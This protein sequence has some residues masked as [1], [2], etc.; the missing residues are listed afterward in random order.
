LKLWVAGVHAFQRRPVVGYGTGGFVR[1]ITPELGLRSNVAHNTYLSVLVEQGIVGLTLYLMMF[2]AVFRSVRRL[3]KLERRFA[4]VLMATVGLAIS[5]LTWE[6]RKPVWF[7]LAVL[8]GLSQAW[9]AAGRVARPENPAW[10][11]PGLRPGPAA[12]HLEP[13]TTRRVG[14][15]AIT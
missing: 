3:P 10:A 14:R 2:V 1:A 5:S 9:L 7:L 12:G 6:H 15:D 8:L 11:G 13:L 4:L